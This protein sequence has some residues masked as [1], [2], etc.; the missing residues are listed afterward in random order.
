MSYSGSGVAFG[1]GI[2]PFAIAIPSV[3]VPVWNVV[4]YPTA[5]GF[6]DHVLLESV[7]P[8]EFDPRLFPDDAVPETSVS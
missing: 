2:H 6:R 8:F 7:E 1:G 5:S 3:V 4:L